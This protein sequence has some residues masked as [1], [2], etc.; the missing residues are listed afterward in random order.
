ML[1]CLAKISSEILHFLSQDVPLQGKLILFIV[2]SILPRRSSSLTIVTV[3]SFVAR[4]RGG[5]Q[6][7]PSFD[8][9]SHSVRHHSPVALLRAR[10]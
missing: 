7:L 10:M 6:L 1:Y 9:F 4:R 2:F 3:A 5:S 8:G